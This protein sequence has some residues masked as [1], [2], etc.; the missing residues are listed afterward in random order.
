V[1]SAPRRRPVVA[2]DGPA[3]A[4]KSTVTRKVAERLGYVI[5]DTGALYRVVALAAERAGVDFD[6][7]VKASTLAEALVAENAVQLRRTDGGA[8]QVLLR[9]QDVSLAIR[10]QNIGQ[11]A[12][13]VSAHPGVRAALLELQRSQGRE[14]GVVLEGRDIGTVVFP[15]AEAKFY[16]TASVD[17]R[18]QRRRDELAARG[19]PPTLEEVLN[20][21][22]ERD[23]R[24]S[25]RP[26]APLRQA[27][28]AKLVDS[29][30]LSIEQVVELIVATVRTVE[31]ELSSKA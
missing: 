1:S 20:E 7:D 3:G 8:M 12:S 10:A 24:D 23:R 27:D 11:G 4:G 13:K 22:A 29:S 28:D 30:S 25:T 17:V 5:V 2:I 9:G 26:I 18:A 31:R 19:T 15:D 16:L 21:V 14:G 6:D